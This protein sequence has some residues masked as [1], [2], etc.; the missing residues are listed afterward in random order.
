M[1][2]TPY[3]ADPNTPLTVGTPSVPK[4]VFT[5]YQA[6]TQPLNVGPDTSSNQPQGFQQNINAD[7]TQR[8]QNLN[9][10]INRAAAGKESI[11][12][13]TSSAIGQGAGAIGDVIF[14]GLNSITGGLLKK[15]AS[16]VGQTAPVQAVTQK[17]NDWS[18]KH[19][20]AADELGAIINVGSLYLGAKGAQ[21]FGENALSK[22]SDIVGGVRNAATSDESIWEAI[23]PKITPGKIGEAVGSGDITM[24]GGKVTQVIDKPLVDA[25]SPYI[26]DPTNPVK[27]VEGLKNGIATEAQALETAVGDTGGTWSVNNVKGLVDEVKIP[28]AIKTVE[29]TKAVADIKTFLEETAATQPKTA[30]GALRLAKDFRLNVNDV[31]PAN[32]WEANTSMGKYIRAINQALNDFA[33]SHI[34][35]GTVTATGKTFEESLATQSKLFDALENAQSKMGTSLEKGGGGIEIGQKPPSSLKKIM[36]KHPTATKVIKYGAA[37]TAGGEVLRKTGLLP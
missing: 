26:S 24:Q 18:Q 30:A 37:A 20:E 28:P 25:V 7:F 3:Q 31:L 14:E 16:A 23:K 12:G 13:A 9:E 35:E 17:V 34:P 29:G 22:A 2:F 10:S 11:I 4:G 1:P 33:S 32:V 19:P 27:V 5:P 36:I 6:P 15:A 8:G 21:S